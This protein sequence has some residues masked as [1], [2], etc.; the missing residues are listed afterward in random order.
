MARLLPREEFLRWFG[1]FLPRL[2]HGEPANLLKPVRVSDPTDPKIAHLIGLNLNRGWV[3][4]RL[5][6]VFATDDPRRALAT[7]AAQAHYEAA[8]PMLGWDDFNRSHWLT[9]FAVYT[10][11]E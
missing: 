4:R 6:G 2:A 9:S 5:A 1:R 10:L 3:W 8:L 7:Q 11:T